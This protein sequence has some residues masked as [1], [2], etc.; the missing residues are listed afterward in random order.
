MVTERYLNVAFFFKYSNALCTWC[1]SKQL[2]Q[3]DTQKAKRLQI[4]EFEC[5]IFSRGYHSIFSQLTPWFKIV[6]PAMVFEWHWSQVVYG[7]PKWWSGSE[8]RRNCLTVPS[9]LSVIHFCDSP[10]KTRSSFS[11]FLVLQIIRHLA[12]TRSTHFTEFFSISLFFVFSP[13]NFLA[14]GPNYLLHQFTGFFPIFFFLV[15]Q[16]FRYLAQIT[17][18]VSLRDCSPSFFCRPSNFL[19]SGPNCS[20]SLQAYC[21]CPARCLL[22][23][24]WLKYYDFLSALG[25]F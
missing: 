8:V 11:I 16:I 10:F 19:V 13:S 6:F 24:F 3:W 9:K 5:W 7:L 17:C 22:G 4:S 12:Q 14:S 2:Y 18:S 20:I 15:L 25:A 23:G 1:N 21:R